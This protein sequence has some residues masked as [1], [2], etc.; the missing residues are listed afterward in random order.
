[1]V[2]FQV[3]KKGVFALW[4][5]KSDDKV[6]DYRLMFRSVDSIELGFS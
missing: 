5:E 4:C 2:G 3:I 1:M 6:S